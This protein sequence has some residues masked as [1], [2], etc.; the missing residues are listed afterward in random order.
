MEGGGRADR[1]VRRLGQ[2]KDGE[3]QVEEEQGGQSWRADN[4]D[5]K[6][7]GGNEL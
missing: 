3:D 4:L 5:Q 1:A 7:G 6:L 2:K